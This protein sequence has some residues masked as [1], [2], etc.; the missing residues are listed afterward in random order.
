MIS[1]L[2]IAE[3][4]RNGQKMGHKE[5]GIGLFKKLQELIIKYVEAGGS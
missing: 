3:R 2:E 1:L 4:I 5:W